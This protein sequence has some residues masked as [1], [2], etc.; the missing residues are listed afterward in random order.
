MSGQPADAHAWHARR[1]AHATEGDA[2]GLQQVGSRRK[3]V[4]WVKL[5]GAVHLVTAQAKQGQRRQYGQHNWAMGGI[6]WRA[7]QAPAGS[8][9]AEA[10]A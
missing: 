5:Q 7:L 10:A 4:C 2:I 3:P 8:P 9:Q 1:L 6:K